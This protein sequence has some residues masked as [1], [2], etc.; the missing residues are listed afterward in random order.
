[1]KGLENKVIISTRPL[2]Q[3]DSMI[4]YLTQQGAIVNEFPMIEISQAEIDDNI[5]ETLEQIDSFNWIIFT[6]KNGFKYFRSRV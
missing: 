3:D 5:S 2:S 4:N 1:M 6:S